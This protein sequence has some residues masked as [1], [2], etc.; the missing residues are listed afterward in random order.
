MLAWTCLPEKNY[1]FLS[2]KKMTFVFDGGEEI[3]VSDRADI[4]Y[5]IGR[6]FFNIELILK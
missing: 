4:P 5:D 1:D 3:T 6:A 2:D